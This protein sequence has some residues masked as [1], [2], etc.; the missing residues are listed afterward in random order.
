MYSENDFYALFMQHCLMMNVLQGGTSGHSELG[1]FLWRILRSP[2]GNNTILHIFFGQISTDCVKF[3]LPVS[4]NL[5]PQKL[6]ETIEL[7]QHGSVPWQRWKCVLLWKTL[8]FWFCP[9]I[10]SLILANIV[11]STNKKK[12]SLLEEFSIIKNL[13]VETENPQLSLPTPKTFPRSELIKA[14]ASAEQ[15][16]FIL[17]SI[18]LTFKLYVSIE[19]Q[20]A[21]SWVPDFLGNYLNSRFSFELERE[22]KW[23]IIIPYRIIL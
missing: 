13:L 9:F 1:K 20:T 18:I 17:I 14:L 4:D 19:F 2:G 8:V 16:H 22:G 21:F 7:E 11:R 12:S 5:S 10:S 23:N 3:W 6:S 15:N